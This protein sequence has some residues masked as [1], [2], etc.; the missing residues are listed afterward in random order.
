MQNTLILIYY[1]FLTI[2]TTLLVVVLFIISSSK[3]I[4]AYIGTLHRAQVKLKTTSKCTW[5][6]LYKN[7]YIYILFY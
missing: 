3:V 7:K 2:I 5:Q 6:L 1:Y 4:G